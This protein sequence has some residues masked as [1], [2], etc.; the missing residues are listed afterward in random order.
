MSD[1]RSSSDIVERLRATA[2]DKDN[3]PRMNSEKWLPVGLAIEAADEIVRGRHMSVHLERLVREWRAAQREIDRTPVEERK[4]N[5]GPLHRLIAAHNALLK[6][7][8]EEL[9]E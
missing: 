3:F 6:Y 8:N 9:G 1:Q 7:A 4:N 5:L 2:L